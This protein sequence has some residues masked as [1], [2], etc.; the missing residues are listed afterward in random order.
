MIKARSSDDYL[1]TDVIL[2]KITEYDVFV[3]YCPSFKELN[4]KFCSEL[5]K[6]RSPTASVILWNKK[7]LYKDFGHA[8]HSFNCFEYI[9]CKYGCTFMESLQRIDCDFNLGLNAFKQEH[10]FSMGQQGSS[11]KQPDLKAASTFI[12]KKKRSWSSDD[13]NF[14][15][16]YFISKEILLIF[17]V[18]PISY[19][20]VNENRFSCK[21]V[22]YAYKFGPRYKIYAPYE[23]EYKWSS[24]VKSTD[25]QGLKQ[26]PKTGKC[27]ILTS[28]LKDI[29]CLKAA[30]FNAIALQSEMQMPDTNLIQNLYTRFEEIIV[31]YDNDYDNENNPG[32]T[33]AK[34]VCEEFNL[35]NVYIPDKYESKDPSDLVQNVGSLTILKHL[36][37][38]QRRCT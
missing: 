1:H 30:G 5:R 25:I 38:E 11:G 32:Q 29:M 21:T 24:N 19:Y 12:R 33:M 22:T 7:L 9:Q 16:K 3:Y 34:K 4:K 23:S 31:F 26:L 37:N 6:D 27:L 17:E 8:E 10:L 20:W 13:R 18:E 35:S 14:W 15:A 2:S 36:I 28:S